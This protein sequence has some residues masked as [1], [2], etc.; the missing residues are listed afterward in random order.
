MYTILTIFLTIILTAVWNGQVISWKQS[1][2]V[3][4]HKKWSK[5]WHRTGFII[6]ALLFIPIILSGQLWAIFAY[7][8]LSYPV[9][10][11]VI[12]TYFPDQPIFYIGATAW[13]D[14]KIPHELQYTIYLFLA[15]ATIY[16]A[17]DPQLNIIQQAY[18]FI[19]RL[20]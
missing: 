20:M 12:N 9:Y 5:R 11:A 7:L 8:F 14:R 15:I 1:V 13:I 18:E 10:N 2:Y 17:I 6:R 3:F 4:E 19:L 16:T